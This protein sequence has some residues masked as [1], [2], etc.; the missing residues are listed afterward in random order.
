MKLLLDT[1]YLLPAIGVSIR[2]LPQAL[3]RDLRARGHH[4]S[5]CTITMFELAAKGARLVRDED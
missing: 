5:I 1:S 3:V 4:I 2:H